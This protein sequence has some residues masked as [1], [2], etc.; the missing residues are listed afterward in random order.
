MNNES[1]VVFNSKTE[2]II[3]TFGNDLT[4]YF[5]MTN[6]RALLEIESYKLI[7]ISLANTVSNILEKKINQDFYTNLS[8]LEKQGIISYKKIEEH[9]ARIKKAKYYSAT[10]TIL[11]FETAPYVIDFCRNIS[12]KNN[13]I[14]FLIGWSAYINKKDDVYSRNQITKLL[15][16][17]G[18]K[19]NSEQYTKYFNKYI[20]CE[21][22]QISSLCLS[23][24]S[25]NLILGASAD[26]LEAIAKKFVSFYNLQDS[27]N[28]GIYERATD[29]VCSCMGIN[30]N[31]A[32]KIIAQCDAS[33]KCVSAIM[34]FSGLGYVS[35]Y[36]NVITSKTLG[37]Q[38]AYC[39]ANNNP[40]GN[41][42]LEK[43]QKIDSAVKTGK[44]VIK[45]LFNE[46][47]Q[48]I[49][50]ITSALFDSSASQVMMTTNGNAD[51]N[52][53]IDIF[54]SKIEMKEDLNG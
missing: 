38:F 27:S 53:S 35:Y 52:R 33:E 47:T 14:E 51:I 30:Q 2:K 24:N 4:N 45:T 23:R 39:N 42:I 34:D 22:S 29:F 32:E 6:A 31:E 28:I 21:Q 9:E 13:I 37:S 44:S 54:E 3:Q 8:Q 15:N 41:P 26:N 17:C 7:E 50:V 46:I 48:N 20:N 43:K 19:I 40:Y 16:S 18:I 10:G 5:N 25:R 12:S 36:E 1:Q 11:L 49:P